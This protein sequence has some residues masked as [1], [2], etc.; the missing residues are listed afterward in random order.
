[1]VAKSCTT[2][3]MGK[4]SVNSGINHLSTGDSDFATIHRMTCGKPN[5]KPPFSIPEVGLYVKKMT[6][7]SG[8]TQTAKHRCG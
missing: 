2:K 7:G 3:R 6:D 8:E 5:V 1:M 4:T